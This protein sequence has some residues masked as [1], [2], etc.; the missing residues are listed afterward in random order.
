MTN[1]NKDRNTHT[2]NKNNLRK[3]TI[4]IEIKYKE[5]KGF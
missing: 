2:D 3:Q 4:K 5:N 1:K